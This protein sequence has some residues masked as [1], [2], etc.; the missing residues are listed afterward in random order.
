MQIKA[1]LHG[2]PATEAPVRYRKRIG[3]SK[4]SGTVRGVIGAGYK[5]LGTI[6]VSALFARS[7]PLL[8]ALIVFS[9]YPEAGKTK[10]RLIPALGPEGAAE[11]QRR[12]TEHALS[13]AVP[14]RGNTA[15]EVR[16]E[17]GGRHVMR[18]WLGP[19]YAYAPQGGGDLGGRMLRAFEARFAEAF[20]KAVVI[21]TDCPELDSA[22]TV[23][24]FAALDA[25]DLVIGPATDGGYYLIGLRM[26]AWCRIEAMEALF[27]GV[28]WGESAV[29]GDTLANAARLGLSVH[30]L[31]PLDDV[32]RPED[33]EV[34]TR[35]EARYRISVIIPTLDEAAC[36]EDA[37]A[38]AAAGTNI[39]IIVVDGGS[40]DDTV[41]LAKAQGAQV[42][43]APRGR[44]TQ[45]NAGA[46]AATA[47]ILLFLHADTRLPQGYDDAVRRCI[48]APGA[49]LGAFRLKIDAPGWGY[50]YIE[51]TANWRSRHLHMPYGDQAPFLRRDTFIEAGRF[52]E[53]PIMEDYILARTLRQQGRVPIL[54]APAA[55]SPRRWQ[56]RGLLAT[57]LLNIF[58]YF[59][60]PLGLDTHRI[61]RLYGKR[62]GI[63]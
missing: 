15:V 18:R 58:V 19:R 9:R 21:G 62:G 26:E 55:T 29:R 2:V 1:A 37:L 14:P 13:I 46:E 12:M 48:A 17:G 59:A 63:Q 23:A 16:F 10:T 5:I 7:H 47:G 27:D 22:V 6:F 39:E 20:G 38:S 11:Q 8:N 30:E 50:R 31:G 28:A 45:M 44:A 41:A 36:I 4:V 52:P 56:R 3:A 49:V 43:E 60:H 40:E 53:L 57:T 51:A 35:A 32:D 54:D 61:A 33:L 24:A 25:H 42:L 34:W